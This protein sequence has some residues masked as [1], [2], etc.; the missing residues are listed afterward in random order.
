M[1]FTIGCFICICI[2]IYFIYFSYYYKEGIQNRP[3]NIVLL[4]D[5][6]FQNQNYVPNSKSIEYLLKEKLTIPSLVLA[7]DNA[8]IH[9][10]PIQYKKLPNTMNKSSTNLYISI[11]GNDLLNV[12]ENNKINNY[13]LF[14]MVWELYK[15]TILNLINNTKCNVILSDIY[16]IT[17]S[18]YTK[19]IPIIKKWNSNLYKFANKHNIQVFKISEILTK[20]KDFTNGIEPSILGGTKIVN[21]FIF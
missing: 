17:D 19:Y 13:K 3:S 2:I 7:E 14:D 12:Y 10:I 4:G 21:S 15:Q 8:V 11:G 1:K 5:S 20:S 6:I 18:N 9:N 16:Y